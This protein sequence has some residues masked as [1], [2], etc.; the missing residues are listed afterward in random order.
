M[1]DDAEKCAICGGDMKEIACPECEKPLS[2]IA[3]HE[4]Y[5]CY[6]CETYAPKGIEMSDEERKCPECD[7]Y[8]TYVSQYDRWYCFN[9]QSYAPK[10]EVEET[11]EEE[12]EE[13]EEEDKPELTE[14]IVEASKRDDLVALCR[15]YGLKVGGKKKALQ[16]RLLVCIEEREEVRPPEEE[17]PP[18]E[19]E[20]EVPEEKELPE[21]PE[22]EKLPAPPEEEAPP[23]AEEEAE[24]EPAE[25]APEEEIVP[26]EADLEKEM[27][28]ILVET[29]V[30]EV[31]EAPPK[32]EKP[33]E[34]PPPEE[35]PPVEEK[36][37]PAVAMAPP[38]EKPGVRRCSTCGEPLTYIAKYER[39]FCSTCKKYAPEAKKAEAKVKKCQT[40]GEPLTYYS[41]Y[42]RWYCHTCRK[43][44]A[45]E[46]KRAEVAVEEGTCPKC[47]GKASYVEKYDRWY[48]PTCKSYLPVKR[49]AVV[50]K[51]KAAKKCPTCGE[52]LTY[53]EKH[54]RHY[55]YVCAKYAPKET[56]A[57]A[58]R[59]AAVIVPVGR[60]GSAKAGIAMIATGSVF[61]L[62]SG[63]LTLLIA[64]GAI[65]DFSFY[66]SA[67]RIVTLYGMSLT[68]ALFDLF[69]FLGIVFVLFG[70]V[71]GLV[72]T[73]SPKTR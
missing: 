1:P 35:K 15:A 46:V 21:P 30:E 53:V 6:E 36:V 59:P 66:E 69:L 19:V 48:C 37:V 64:V 28:E 29:G 23:E 11:P 40:C 65:S 24:E 33:S 22:E 62:V 51:K 38:E 4:R 25:E 63:L 72:A 34:A 71:A 56:R 44:A 43:Y 7:K 67:G 26:E 32:E 41:Q 9:C 12:L 39:W 55:C 16:D 5:Y 10:E 73:T 31:P 61:F 70:V 17:A 47:H 14:E 27:E 58:V 13:P 68:T 45:K 60:S 49:P 42:D 8:L 20:E 2:Y 18:E 50:V 3:E 57:R 54:D 52:D